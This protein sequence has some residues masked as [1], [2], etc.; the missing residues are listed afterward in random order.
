[1]VISVL[2]IYLI[3]IL[4]LS[5]AQ[6][7]VIDGLYQGVASLVQLASG[8]VTDRWRKYKEV[9]GA[10]YAVSAVCRLGL[11]GTGT[12]PGIAAIL[13]LDRLGKGFRTAP[14]DALISLSVP[15]DHLGLAFGVHRAM[16]AMGAMLGPIIAFA[17]LALIPG[18]FDVIFVS[19]FC[20]ALVGLAV[21]MFFVENLRS[22]EREPEA[23]V[24]LTSALG[25]LRDGTFRRLFVSALMLSLTTVSDAFVYLA[26]QRELNLGSGAFPLLY[27]VT[28][29]SYLVLAVPAGRLADRAGRLT[30]FC[31]GY[32]LLLGLYALL[33]WGSP[34][35]L[36][37]VTALLTL[38]AHYAAT[39]GVLMALGSAHLPE[40]VR[41]SGLAILTTGTAVARFGASALFGLLWT[42]LGLE[43]AIGIFLL[44][45]IGAL[46]IT[47]AM[48]PRGAARA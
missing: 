16:D 23:P 46:A 45:L 9:A 35:P 15:R 30:V 3:T 34:G 42:Q 6:F 38:G 32:G 31:G 21:L 37:L 24:D 11:L 26:L 20:I 41:S 48:L 43:L 8:L 13:I 17:L 39:E 36:L 44:G 2:P 19:S 47:L 18:A 5:P 7:G 4:R 12:G 10:G 25:L 27:V 22:S 40:A 28:S 33:L 1:M 14:R 29:L